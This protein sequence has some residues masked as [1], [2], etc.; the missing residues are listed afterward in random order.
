MYVQVT[1][2]Q[3]QKSMLEAELSTLKSQLVSMQLDA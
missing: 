1:E 2:L 3:G